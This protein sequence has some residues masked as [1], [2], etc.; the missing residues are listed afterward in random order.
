MI[1]IKNDKINVGLLILASVVLGK[2]ISIP[3][4]IVVASILSPLNFGYLALVNTIVQY[5]TYSRLGLLMNMTREIPISYG[6]NDI[7]DVK[8]TYNVIFTNYVFSTL[9]SIILLLFLWLFGLGDAL[10]IEKSIWVFCSIIF[11]SSN[12]TSFFNAYLKAEGK[13]LI[14]SQFEIVGSVVG[15]LLTLILVYFFG[16]NGA[17]LALIFSDLMASIFMFVKSGRPSFHFKFSK[18]KSISLY[19]TGNVMFLSQ[20]LDGLLL[21]SGII[22]TKYY[23]EISDVGVFSFSLAL[24]SLKK[25]PFAKALTIMTNREMA[26]DYGN[27]ASNSIFRKYFEKDLVM[28]LILCV[29]V[30]GAAFFIFNVTIVLFLPKYK[31]GVDL[32]LIFLSTTVLYN[33]RIFIYNY[34]DLTKNHRVR[35][36]TSLLGIIMTILFSKYFIS[37]NFGL[38]GIGLSL[39]MSFILMSLILLY[40]TFNSIFESKKFVYL[41]L[42]KLIVLTCLITLFVYTFQYKGVIGY[43]SNYN[44]YISSILVLSFQIVTF[45]LFTIFLFV[46]FFKNFLIYEQIV[47]IITAVVFKF[48]NKMRIK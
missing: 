39:S 1:K 30:V 47:R 48:R 23:F 27:Y 43:F 31:I 38:I 44:L 15:P 35:L 24:L 45:S 42:I 41:Y 21:S 40:T 3:G 16:L 28:F 5:M 25:I 37:K 14:Y 46:V 22:I 20:L 17:L 8:L 7:S 29:L 11:F 2:L 26:L 6:K 32:M 4:N 33:G 9:F 12:I 10:G 18:S 36:F 34:F 19:R 13:F